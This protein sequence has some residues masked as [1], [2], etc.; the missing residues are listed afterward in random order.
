M[1]LTLLKLRLKQTIGGEGLRGALKFLAPDFLVGIFLALSSGDAGESNLVYRFALVSAGVALFTLV[2]ETRRFFFSGGDTENFYFVQPTAL[3]RLTSMLS[4]ILLDLAVIVSVMIPLFLLSSTAEVYFS[5]IV[6]ASLAAFCFSVSIYFL[7]LFFVSSLPGRAANLS[8]TL[9]QILLALALLAVFQL[10]SGAKGITDFS[11]LIWF[12]LVS[13]FIISFF[14]AA[15][16]FPEKLIAKLN[17]SG[18]TSRVDLQSIVERIKT[19][20]FIRSDEEE[21]GSIFFLS[22]LFRNSSFRLSTIAIAATPV[23][24]AIYWSMQKTPFLR[25]DLFPGFVDAEFVAPI[26]SLVVAGVMVHYFLSQN[27]LGSRDHEASWLIETH[28]DFNIGK[29]VLGFRKA[30][31]LT[32]HIPMVVAI[33]FV[34]IF[35]NSLLA[36]AITAITFYFLTHVSASWFSIMQK[37]FPFS[38][39]FTRI[40][41][42]ETANLI[43]MLA[44]SFIV[45]V[46]LYFSYGQIE[47]LLMVNILAFI[48]VGILE[49]F[50]SRIV[51]KRVK[52]SV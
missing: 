46:V 32:I 9:L 18:S 24:V 27:L 51:N 44:Y 2:V 52:L 5:E 1:I 6:I 17:E 41:A 42:L 33:F 26:A 35:R 21:A 11:S 3:F 43:F 45:T 48:L 38:L 40:G 20:V 29:F 13:L 4:V 15:F 22:N 36:S 34:L 10:S 49:L 16:P 47:K 8:L 14:F 39:P 19:A 30:L 28:G 37:K 12:S 7:L 31:L 23:M 25:F 50:S